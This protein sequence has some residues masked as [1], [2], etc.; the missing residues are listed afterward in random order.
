VPGVGIEPTRPF[1]D[2]GILSRIDAHSGITR[3]HSRTRANA[4][5]DKRLLTIGRRRKQPQRSALN[6]TR[7][8]QFRLSFKLAARAWLLLVESDS[9]RSFL[10][11]TAM[12]ILCTLLCIALC[13]LALL[14]L[15]DD[16]V[17]FFHAE[18]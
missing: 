11:L 2:L 17:R 3:N 18:N 13:L 9:S 16:A 5:S 7:R 14:L 4:L 12:L 10:N 6:R 1:W 15:T 8:D